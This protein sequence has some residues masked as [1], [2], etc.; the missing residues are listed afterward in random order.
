RPIEALSRFLRALGVPPDQ[1]PLDEEEAADLYRTLLADR[2]MLILL[3]N[4]RSAEQVRP[5]LPGSPSCLVLV[6][7]RDRLGG[8]VARDGARRGRRQAGGGAGRVRP[9]LRQPV[10]RRATAVPAARPR[11]GARLH[12]RHGGGRRGRRRRRGAALAERADRGEPH[13]RAGT[14]PPRLP[15]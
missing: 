11:P 5:L 13:R 10:A 9:V 8:L 1:V 15:R 4:A 14:G 12:G 7:S 3:D 2:R 6:T